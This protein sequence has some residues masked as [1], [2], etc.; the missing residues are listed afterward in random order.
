MLLFLFL[1]LVIADER[2]VQRF[3]FTAEQVRDIR[4]GYCFVRR[5]GEIEFQRRPRCAR[6]VGALEKPECSNHW[7]C[8]LNKG[9]KGIFS[10]NGEDGIL[11]QLLRRFNLGASGSNFVEFGVED[12][13]EC[14]TRLLREYYNWQGVL[15]DGTYANAS[16]NLHREFISESNICALFETYRVARDLTLLVVD[17][18]F[19]DYHVL[20]RILTCGYAPSLIVVEYNASFGP[21]VSWSVPRAPINARWDGTTVNWFQI[22]VNCI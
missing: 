5:V 17:I 18:D 4:N 3:D 14:V 6:M 21:R 19:H 8:S 12:G 11:L 9:E 10:Q 13:H 7:T 16:I 1:L 2:Q 20:E 22:R 15:F